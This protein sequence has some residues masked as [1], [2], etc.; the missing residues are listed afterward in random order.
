MPIRERRGDLGAAVAR[1]LTER[2]LR[3]L[4]DVR[5]AA[6]TSQGTVARAAGISPSQLS[7]LERNRIARPSIEQICRVAGA[8]GQTPSLKLFPSGPAVRD[9]GQLALLARFESRLGPP[10]HDRREVPLSIQGDPRAWD[11]MVLGGVEPFFEE[12]ESHLS[13][14]Q[15][16]ARRVELKLRDDG[17][18]R[19]VILVVAR[20]AYN[21]RVLAAHRESLRSQFP[22]DG[23]AI[24]RA[25]RR[26]EAPPASGIIVV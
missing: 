24:A 15:A 7:R 6:G 14:V 25:V 10:L 18:A 4:R 3:E 11:G 8:L 21:R 9:S 5:V 20:S 17:R 16:L 23:A 26:G 22:L 2:A 19:V 13:D 12:G 1:R